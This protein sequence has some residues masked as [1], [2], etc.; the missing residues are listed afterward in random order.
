[1]SPLVL[2][3]SCSG[4]KARPNVPKD[5]A[6]CAYGTGS[7]MTT[8]GAASSVDRRKGRRVARSSRTAAPMPRPGRQ[9]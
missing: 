2:P 6:T 4:A 3:E 9:A 8:G 5:A 1:M 7:T